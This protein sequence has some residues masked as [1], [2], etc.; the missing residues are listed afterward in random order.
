MAQGIA[1][2]SPREQCYHRRSGQAANEVDDSHAATLGTVPDAA[3]RPPLHAEGI[4][5][6]LDH[7][8]G[9]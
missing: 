1:R 8:P 5:H 4:C 7:C 9:P 3:R 6:V 2:N